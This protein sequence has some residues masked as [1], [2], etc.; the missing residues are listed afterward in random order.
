MDDP[1]S[2]IFV[3]DKITG[4]RRDPLDKTLFQMQISWKH[5]ESTWEPEQNIQ[6]DAEEALFEYWDSV[7][8]GRLGAMAD[9]DLWHVLRVEKHKQKPNGTI[10]LLVYWI[11]SPDRSWEPE[12]QVEQYA[13]HHVENYW[14]SKGGRD[15]HIKAIAV[16]VKRGR[17]RP[18]KDTLS[19]VEDAPKGTV[20]KKARPGRKQK[21]DEFEES[22]ADKAADEVI[23]SKTAEL[24]AT[25]Q[26]DTDGEPPKK[27]GRGRPR[28]NPVS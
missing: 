22:Q 21:R 16:P 12:S 15:K 10:H 5:D 17:G 11:G 2:G 24:A 25:E 6:E 8:G 28:K 3:L 19:E 1:K 7:K 27:R 14:K 20:E 13:R 9:K 23:A 26:T 4:H 18:R